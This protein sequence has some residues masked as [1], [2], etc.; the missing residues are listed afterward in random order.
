MDVS[1]LFLLFLVLSLIERGLCIK[2]YNCNSSPFQSGR[3]CVELPRKSS[4]EIDCD[5]FQKNY[6]RCRKVVQNVDD[7]VRIIRQC[8]T[9]DGKLGCESRVG[10]KNIKMKYCLC[11]KDRCNSAPVPTSFIS[12]FLLYGF[13]SMVVVI[14]R[15]MHNVF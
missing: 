15:T 11:D 4:F 8:A 3:F 7:D 13:A 1:P 6:T 14:T 12:R 5:L 2:C 10:T 9:S